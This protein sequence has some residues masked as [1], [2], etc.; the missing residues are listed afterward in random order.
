MLFKLA[1]ELSSKE[2]EDHLDRQY[3]WLPINQF[4]ILGSKVVLRQNLWKAAGLFNG[5]EGIL[6]DIIFNSDGSLKC[7]LVE[8]D[9]FKGEG[10][11]ARF[12]N[13]SN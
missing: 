10:W 9:N 3:L 4:F 11:V 12:K 5:S 6:K 13:G 2:V 7:L 1:A 8:F